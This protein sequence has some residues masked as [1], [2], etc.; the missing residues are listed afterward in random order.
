MMKLNAKG[1]QNQLLQLLALFAIVYALVVLR[2]DWSTDASQHAGS[3]G[4][5]AYHKP[6]S[7]SSNAINHYTAIHF[8]QYA[9]VS[10]IR[11]I[12]LWHIAIFSVIWE[13]FELYT[14]FEWGRESWL[15]KFIDIIF[16]I[17]GF[18][19]GRITLF[20]YLNKKPS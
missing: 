14:H 10:F 2:S 3:S 13:I 12:K 9:V 17:A 7:F 19:F 1:I 15:N 4:L 16:N 18:Q 11:V 5:F 20:N 6:E 8:F